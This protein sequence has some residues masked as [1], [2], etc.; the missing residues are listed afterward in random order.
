MRRLNTLVFIATAIYATLDKY[1]GIEV[2]FYVYLSFF[3]FVVINAYLIHRELLEA[4]KVFGLI[5]FNVMIFLVAT[6]EPFATG[7]HLHY[8]TSGAVALALYGYEQW[9]GAIFFVLLALVLDIITFTSGTSFIPYRDVSNEQARVFFVL[10][11]LICASVCVYTFMIYSKINYESQKSLEEN[12]S[13]IKQQNEQLI[14]AN[15]E[16]DR[17]VYSAS[18]DLRSPLSSLTGLINLS[19]IETDE[20]LKTKYLNLMKER[21]KSMDSFIGEIIDYSRNSRLEV[22]RE[23]LNLKQL[24]KVIMEELKYI[25]GCD[26]VKVQWHV[27]SELYIESDET[28]LKIIFN[29]L[30]TNAI[31]YRDEKKEDSYLKIS[32]QTLDN[33]LAISIE[34][35]GIG[36]NENYL[37]RVFDMFYRA[38]DHSSGSGLGLYIVKETV[39]K[40]RGTINVK[41]TEWLGSVFTVTLPNILIS[42]QIETARS[43]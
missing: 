19:K 10:N 33:Q 28:R 18:H 38:H 30:I 43:I 27:D 35:N 36:I 8:V 40:L 39:A 12:D 41:S 29:N 4:S 15:Q 5:A 31:K 16:L 20:D 32:A 42:N 37:S 2:E 3:L 26:K 24:L 21:V 9:K 1:L 34:D 7:M 17:F 22:S 23:R 14:K 25:N 6:S 11:T 13:L